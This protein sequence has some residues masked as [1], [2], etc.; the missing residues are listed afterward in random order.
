MALVERSVRANVGRDAQS[1]ASE[2][3]G[4]TFAQRAGGT[5]MPTIESFGEGLEGR[6]PFTV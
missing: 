5:G 2:C 3:L 4:Q 1:A 6:Y